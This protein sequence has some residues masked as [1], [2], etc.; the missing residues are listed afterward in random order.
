MF[1]EAA[2][3]VLRDGA[4]AVRVDGVHGEAALRQLGAV[5]VRLVGGVAQHQVVLQCGLKIRLM[6]SPV[7]EVACF[8]S[9]S[10]RNLAPRVASSIQEIFLSLGFAFPFRNITV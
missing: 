5:A 4:E 6:V 1:A 8:L 9:L 10:R 7:G 2:A 3:G